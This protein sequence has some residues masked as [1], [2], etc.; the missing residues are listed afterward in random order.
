[1]AG[2]G[3]GIATLGAHESSP[4]AANSRDL[5]G[6]GPGRVGRGAG[7]D[8][9]SGPLPSLLDGE[10]AE[11]GNAAVAVAAEDFGDSLAAKTL[12]SATRTSSWSSTEDQYS[13]GYDVTG[14]TCRAE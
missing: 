7:G 13:R 2:D 1:M 12:A 3:D 6:E 11:V 9:R 14:G 10:G 8:M 5:F 4:P